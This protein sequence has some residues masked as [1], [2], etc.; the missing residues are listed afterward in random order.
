MKCWSAALKMDLDVRSSGCEGSLIFSSSG[1]KAVLTVV[2]LAA[3]SR[4]G[5]LGP[6][7]SSRFD[8]TD[9]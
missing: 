9:S 6:G 2:W 1:R 7:S 4:P 3:L 8:A 5:I